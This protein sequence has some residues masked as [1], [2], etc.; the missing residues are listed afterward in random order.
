MVQWTTQFRSPFS[1]V[2]RG[3]GRVTL[4]WTLLPLGVVSLLLFAWGFRS[5]GLRRST[6][7]VALG[8]TGAL[9]IIFEVVILI[10]FQILYG[11]VYSK[12]GIL[13]MGFMVGLTSGGWW[14]TKRLGRKNVTYGSI[15]KIQGALCVYPLAMIAA[16]KGLSVLSGNT[17][18]FLSTEILFPV[19]I[20]FGGFLGGAQFP[21]ANKLYIERGGRVGH[22]GGKSYGID[23][24]G[25][26][27]GAL[28]GGSL[29][30]PILGIWNTCIFLSCLSLFALL[31][32]LPEALVSK[33]AFS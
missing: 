28:I 20:A 19:L 10:G 13:L 27:L 9:E 4:A 25:S 24:L 23:V 30:I 7:L 32:L 16:F 18:V 11:F 26:S 5:V 14:M 21:L 15:L 1:S 2:L 6:L 33:T 31:L 29:L 22:A 8:V 3:F 12:I 17:L